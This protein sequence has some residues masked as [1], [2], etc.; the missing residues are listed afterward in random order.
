MNKEEVYEILMSRGSSASYYL[1]CIVDCVDQIKHTKVRLENMVKH[2][3]NY[4]NK[5]EFISR[6]HW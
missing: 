6:D 2:Q 3:E 5:Q 1:R 4:E